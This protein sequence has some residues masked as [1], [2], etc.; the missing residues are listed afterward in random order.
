MKVSGLTRLMRGKCLLIVRKMKRSNL[1]CKTNSKVV[2]VSEEIG[3]AL[4]D[5]QIKSPECRNSF[6]LC[7]I[8]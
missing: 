7:I 4:S 5:Y 6:N 1:M 8:L 2:C 3:K